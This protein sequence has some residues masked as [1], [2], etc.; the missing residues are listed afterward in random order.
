[1]TIKLEV[2]K[3]ESGASREDGVVPAVVYGP[4]QEATPISVPA[5][6][7]EKT[8]AEAGES[9]IITLS[10]LDE[11]IEVL[12][13]DVAF[14]HAKGGL[15]HVDFY[16]IERGKELTT[17]VALAYVG[18]A[19]AEKGGASVN[20]IMH[21]VEVTC[22][23]SALP[24]EIEVDLSV[25]V[26]EAAAIRVTDLTLP[27]GVTINNEAEDVVVNIVAARAEESE[28]APEAVD[29]GAVEVEAKGKEEANTE[30]K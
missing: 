2:T 30:E 4:K 22:R 19:P 5:R 26:D 14:N 11:E 3:R 6:S 23:P 12:V 29:M 18:E 13:H 28:D 1:M 7:L 25:L 8:L 21:D 27:E 10:G 9:T 15:E 17:N 20:K 16:A 24:S